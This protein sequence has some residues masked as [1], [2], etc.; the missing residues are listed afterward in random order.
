M[1][2]N[3]LVDQQVEDGRKLITTLRSEGFP[4]VAAGWL[5]ESDGGQWFLYIASPEVDANGHKA[6]YGALNAIYRKIGPLWVRPLEIK[7]VGA[8]HPVAKAV[9]DFS[10]RYP[11]P[12]STRLSEGQLGGVP[13]DQALVYAPVAV[14]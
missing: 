1:D 2:S 3:T 5:Q 8:D 14:P 9:E 12:V 6:A 10:R 11:G 13:I 4:V 7:L